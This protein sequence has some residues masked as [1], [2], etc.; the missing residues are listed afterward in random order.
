MEDCTDS[1]V[2]ECYIATETVFVP[3]TVTVC[4]DVFSRRCANALQGD[5]VCSVEYATGT[6]GPPNTSITEMPSMIV[7]NVRIL[8]GHTSELGEL[9]CP[10]R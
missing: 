4:E 8:R 1:F 2:K 6:Y 7:L 10:F 9:L 3:V 5:E